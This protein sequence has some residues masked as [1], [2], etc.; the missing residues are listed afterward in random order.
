MLKDVFWIIYQ[1]LSLKHF[2]IG[3][4][5]WNILW[6][7]ISAS[8]SRIRLINLEGVNSEYYWKHNKTWIE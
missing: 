8:W 6:M 2:N 7:Q 4:I 1:L 5:D 3:F